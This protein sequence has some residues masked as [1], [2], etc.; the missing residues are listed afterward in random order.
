MNRPVDRRR[1]PARIALET[2]PL[3]AFFAAAIWLWRSDMA[4]EVEIVSWGL[5]VLASA[6]Q[7]ATFA[8]R[9]WLMGDMLRRF[10]AP[11][12]YPAAVAAIFK[13]VLSK[14][15]PGKIWLLVSTAGILDRHGIG[16]RLGT[17]VFA[18]FQFTIGV[19]GLALGALALLAFSLPGIEESARLL[20]ILAAAVLIAALLG[21]RGV[22]NWALHVIPALQR[23]SEGIRNFPSL[24][25]PALVSILHWLLMGLAF[26]VFLQAL[27]VD[28]FW[29]AIMFQSL[30][31]NLGV[32]AVIVPGGLGVR[33]GVM[34]AYLNLA[35]LELAYALTLAV[36]AR[37][38]FFAGEVFIFLI[39][40]L[41][42]RTS[43]K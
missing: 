15:I 3:I 31:I 13:P 35:G 42:D 2:L 4:P 27:G 36:A 10:S 22:L 33:E 7:L 18:A 12:P 21:S 11:L 16:F 41:V 30:A 9:A 24:A 39:G 19:T 29:Y 8:M 28:V 5:V 17:L 20:L 6:L 37:L 40:L 1:S 26:A 25:L 32:A 14:Y 43:V 23:W 34:A 38:W